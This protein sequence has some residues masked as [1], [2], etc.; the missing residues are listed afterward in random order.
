MGQIEFDCLPERLNFSMLGLGPHFLFQGSGQFVNRPANPRS[1]SSPKLRA[2]TSWGLL[3]YA[4][5]A[6]EYWNTRG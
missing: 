3:N 5:L 4:P 6:G 1:I 2:Y